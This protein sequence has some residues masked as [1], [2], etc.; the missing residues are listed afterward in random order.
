MVKMIGTWKFK[1]KSNC[2]RSLD[3]KNKRYIWDIF[4]I[5]LNIKIKIIIEKHKY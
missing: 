4:K 3:F 5:K 1:I 2:G